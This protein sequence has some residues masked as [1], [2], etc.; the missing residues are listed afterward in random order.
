MALYSKKLGLLFKHF[1]VIKLF[2]KLDS[3]T[4]R[5]AT[6]YDKAEVKYLERIFNEKDFDAEALAPSEREPK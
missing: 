2:Q 4:G 3:H 6:E 5:G 1:A